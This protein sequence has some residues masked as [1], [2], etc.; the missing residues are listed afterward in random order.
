MEQDQ[1]IYLEAYEKQLEQLLLK[2]STY[3]LLLKGS[4]FDIQELEELWNEMAPEYMADAV[5]EI[6]K[7]PTVAIAWA[8]YIGMAAAHAWDSNW[9]TIPHDSQLYIQWRDK[10]GFDC[11]DEYIL[12]NKL[13]YQSNSEEYKKIEDLMRSLSMLAFN[14]IKKE[15]IEPQSTLAF[16]VFA[17]TTKVMFRLGLSV[18]LNRLGYFYEKQE[19]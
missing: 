6:A 8:G 15:Q 19:Q 9:D 5:P 17:R 3:R 1:T 2:E 18:E 13:N 11:L 14:Q 16:Y 12:E 4:L 10:R 7:Y